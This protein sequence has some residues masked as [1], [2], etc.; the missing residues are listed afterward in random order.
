MS[1]DSERRGRSSTRI[2]VDSSF[3]AAADKGHA[4]QNGI[5]PPTISF[6]P[7]E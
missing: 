1:V 7:K 2:H 5:T 6:G 3:H 4:F